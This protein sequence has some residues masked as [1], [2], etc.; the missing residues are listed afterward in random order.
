ML[1]TG[2]MHWKTRSIWSESTEKWDEVHPSWKTV[3]ANPERVPR[4]RYGSKKDEPKT[5]VRAIEEIFLSRK[6]CYKLV[7]NSGR[8]AVCCSR[9]EYGVGEYVIV[10]ADRGEDC[11][12]IGSVVNGDE[13]GKAGN[14]VSG[15][16]NEMKCIIRKATETDIKIL[17]VRKKQE[18]SALETCMALVKE[19]GY[20]MEILRCEFQWDMK[21]IT[22]YFRSGRRID[23]RDLVRELF[24]YFKIR[25]WMSMENRGKQ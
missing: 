13:I 10:E 16:N 14:I 21:K 5:S 8:E 22:F 2:C 6:M 17:E 11:A 19:K 3:G 24:R 4:N 25:I 15:K 18:K 7:F 20:Q 1:F 23:F 9:N 12:R